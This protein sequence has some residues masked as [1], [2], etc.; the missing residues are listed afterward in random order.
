MVAFQGEDDRR[1]SYFGSGYMMAKFLRG[2]RRAAKHPGVTHEPTCH[3]ARRN[4]ENGRDDGFL[5]EC[6]D[7]CRMER[8]M[9]A[10]LEPQPLPLPIAPP[11]NR[12]NMQRMKPKPSPVPIIQHLDN[13]TKAHPGAPDRPFPLQFFSPSAGW[14][15]PRYSALG[16]RESH[17]SA[18]EPC[19]PRLSVLCVWHSCCSE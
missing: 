17:G 8:M 14:R 15:F 9:E 1:S 16:A 4:I 19:R 12:M 6:S 18:W 2:N 3:M 13:S 5:F 7:K 11:F 10:P